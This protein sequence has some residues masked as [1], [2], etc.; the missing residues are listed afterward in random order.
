MYSITN[1]LTLLERNTI[2][3]KAKLDRKHT[4]IKHDRLNKIR[5]LDRSPSM[6]LLMRKQLSSSRRN[7]S[8]KYSFFTETY[9]S[10]WIVY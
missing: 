6:R 10:D 7:Q 2:Y 4:G 8:R 9:S 1:T 3:K 5:D